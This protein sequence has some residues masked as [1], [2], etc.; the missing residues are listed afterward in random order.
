[1]FKVDLETVAYTFKVQFLHFSLRRRLK[2][3]FTF[4][5]LFIRNKF[6]GF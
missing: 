3:C 4:F 6:P 1:M 2:V 5:G